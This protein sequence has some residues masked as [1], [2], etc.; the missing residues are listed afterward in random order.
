MIEWKVASL[1]ACKIVRERPDADTLTTWLLRL[2][3]Q[4]I[5]E[6]NGITVADIDRHIIEYF[7]QVGEGKE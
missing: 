6:C 7:K 2:I 1:L 5:A 3:E 4:T